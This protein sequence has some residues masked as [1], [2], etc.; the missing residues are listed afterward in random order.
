MVHPVVF[1][2][3]WPMLSLPNERTKA[4]QDEE[5]YLCQKYLVYNLVIEC[6]QKLAKCIQLQV[7]LTYT[8]FVF[9][10]LMKNLLQLANQM[11]LADMKLKTRTDSSQKFTHD[12]RNY[13]LHNAC[14]QSVKLAR[15]LYASLLYVKECYIN[16]NQ[17]KFNQ[18]SP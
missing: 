10:F 4:K 7:N 15:V 11:H 17:V 18:W 14:N 16:T 12:C 5:L 13:S 8:G 3:A 1:S 2:V 9:T 6:V